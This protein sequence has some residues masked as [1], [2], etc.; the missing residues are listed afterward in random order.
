[1]PIF[2]LSTYNKKDRD[3][4]T[5]GKINISKVSKIWINKIPIIEWDVSLRL[6]HFKN[7]FNKYITY[8]LYVLFILGSN[9]NP[10]FYPLAKVL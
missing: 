3:L 10:E 4:Y 8:T 1:M 9:Q 5:V 7:T 2:S 6:I